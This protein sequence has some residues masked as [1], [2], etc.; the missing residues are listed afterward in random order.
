MRKTS[1]NLISFLLAFIFLLP[2][3][4]CGQPTTSTSTSQPSNI[5]SSATY[6]LTITNYDSQEHLV[7]YTYQKTPERVVVT[8]P[9]A[10]ELLLE[11]GLQD[12]ILSTVAP[13]GPPLDRLANQYRALIIMKAQ[14]D[15]SQ[16]EIVEMQPHMIISWVHQFTPHGI[17]DVK[18]WNERG[19]ATFVMPST[20]T[21]TDPTLETVVYAS[22]SDLGK[23]FNIQGKTDPYI[24]QLKDR[25]TAI[26][27]SLKDVEQKKTIMVLQDHYNGTF[28]LYDTHY[29]ISHMIHIAGGKN[30]CETPA[31]F[32][33]AEKVLAFDPDFIIFVTSNGNDST[34]DLTDEEA[35]HSLKA[36]KELRSMRAI[37]EGNI[38][39]LPFFTVNNGGIRTIDAIEKIARTLY[40]E[41]VK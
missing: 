23:I 39:N 5:Q 4:G 13:Y 14:Y 21:K 28:S 38:I 15:P 24:Q 41:R 8:H 3:T 40:P 20:L 11:L 22:I 7:S 30:I 17:G 2:L 27:K 31:S 36:I 32:V 25:V 6:P 35:V 19:V 1:P 9:G 37:Q 18:T 10:T 12:R 29:L 16:E 34:K 26:E 33:G